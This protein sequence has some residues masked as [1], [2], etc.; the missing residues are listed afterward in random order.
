[1]GPVMSSEFRSIRTRRNN[2]IAS[3]R[4]HPVE[5]DGHRDEDTVRNAHEH[6]QESHSVRVVRPQLLAMLL[7]KEAESQLSQKT[8]TTGIVPRDSIRRA[9]TC[10]MTLANDCGSLLF[11]P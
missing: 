8:I 11:Q 2:L 5:L 7:P 9:L 4:G 3:A 1:M 6:E 10:R